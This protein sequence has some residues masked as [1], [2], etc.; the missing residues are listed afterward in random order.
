[1]D[2]KSATPISGN[3]HI[4]RS[5]PFGFWKC[6]D[7]ELVE[8]IWV[9]PLQIKHPPRN[10]NLAWMKWIKLSGGP[11]WGYLI[12]G[13]PDNW[14]VVG[15]PL[16]K[17]W[18]RQLGWWKQPNMSGKMP[19]MAT[20][21]PTRISWTDFREVKRDFAVHFNQPRDDHQSQWPPC[22]RW[23]ISELGTGDY[24]IWLCLQMVYTGRTMT[25]R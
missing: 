13:E 22:Q 23:S 10:V 5:R 8:M 20:K 4:L 15:P 7:V 14:L 17:I 2:D 21:P 19:K 18:V 12:L 3:F 25:M 16:W 11:L 9:P 6:Q 24:S 1:M